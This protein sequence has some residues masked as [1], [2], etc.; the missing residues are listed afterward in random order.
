[1]KIDQK[2]IG[3]SV[4]KAE[5][6]KSDENQPE[7]EQSSQHSSPG[8]QEAP[9]SESTY[10]PTIMGEHVARPSVLTGTT[11]KIEKSP[12]SEHAMYVTI[13]DIVLDHGTEHEERLPFEI[14]IN[15]KNM[16]QFQWVVAMTRIISA[17]FRKG[18]DVSFLA[19]EMKAVFDPKGGYFKAGGYIPSLVA[20]IGQ[21]I[22]KHL[23][24]LGLID[25]PELDPM[26]AALI[27][28]KKQALANS[29]KK[30]PQQKTANGTEQKQEQQEAQDEEGL[31]FPANATLCN[32]CHQKSVVILDGCAT[33][34]NCGNSKCG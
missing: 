3:Y 32:K 19:E 12:A 14:F 15:S 16:D 4:V 21:I 11:Y 29:G 30:K 26:A 6:I 20:E 13:N 22:E 9:A 2:I 8:A 18:G 5:E 33:C 28:E 10:E 27:A 1:M 7:V 23:Q 17:V 31:Q 25:K 24:G 34:L